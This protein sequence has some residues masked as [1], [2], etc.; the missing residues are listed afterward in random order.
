MSNLKFFLQLKQII[1]FI[2]AER[3]QEK[4][5]QNAVLSSITEKIMIIYSEQKK[6]DKRE[7]RKRLKVFFSLFFWNF[8]QARS[9][10]TLTTFCFLIKIILL[11]CFYF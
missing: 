1:K 2:K 9:D 7:K 10:S 8:L 5:R 11:I 6:E 3:K 4:Q